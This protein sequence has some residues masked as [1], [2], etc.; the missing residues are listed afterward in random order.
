MPRLRGLRR[1][2]DVRRYGGGSLPAMLGRAARRMDS[3]KRFLG[4]AAWPAFAFGA[5]AL[6][7]AVITLAAIGRL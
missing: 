7:A 6:G 5:A 1:L 4:R 2:L 3:M